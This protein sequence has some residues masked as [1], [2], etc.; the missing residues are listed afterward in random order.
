[1]AT[2]KKI[3]SSA[4]G[5]LTPCQIIQNKIDAKNYQMEIWQSELEVLLDD[6]DSDIDRIGTLRGVVE[7]LNR[8]LSRLKA[9][10]RQNNCVSED[11]PVFS[12]DNQTI[13]ST[14]SVRRKDRFALAL[15]VNNNNNVG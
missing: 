11:K 3:S 1:M 6:P 9:E 7:D 10:Q 12:N 4:I 8:D 15:P 14:S 5:S 13:I 2:Q